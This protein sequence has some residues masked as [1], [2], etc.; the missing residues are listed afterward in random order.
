MRN[1]YI[2]NIGF[3]YYISIT[4]KLADAGYSIK[5]VSHGEDIT[6]Q[7]KS[8]K[9]FKSKFKPEVLTFDQYNYP[10]RFDKIFD[11]DYSIF[12]TSFFAE[13]AYYE[14]LFL[15]MSDR[16]CF[17]PISQIERIRL[18]H[19]YIAHAY[20]LFKRLDINSIIF[21]GTPHGPWNISIIALSKVMN[22][23]IIYTDWVGLSPKLTTIEKNIEIRKSITSE[24][25]NIDDF[26]NR[27]DSIEINN[28]INEKIHQ[29]LDWTSTKHINK[30]AKILKRII[31][32]A[33]IKSVRKYL[34]P[35]FILNHSN[36][37]GI[38]YVTKYIKHLFEMNDAINFYDKN[39]ISKIE[40]D[41]WVF[42][43]HFQPE[44]TTMPMGYVYSDQLLVL[45]IILSAAPANQRIFIK[46]HP[47]TY[48]Y[49][50][51]D[52][53]ERSKK[54]YKQLLRDPRVSF[55][56]RKIE[57]KELINKAKYIISICGSVSW[58]A[59][60]IGKP[61]I[62][63][64]W[65]WFSKCKSIYSVDS[66]ESLKDAF[67]QINKSNQQKVQND[68][69]EFIK[70]IKS[71]SIYGVAVRNAFTYIDIN[72]QEYNQ[73]I[74]NISNGIIKSLEKSKE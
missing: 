41:S 27:Q 32:L 3:D 52:R 15:L 38:N 60:R 53:H 39:S 1:L 21:F 19:R 22:I 47:F 56:N 33:T 30:N 12:S 69:D 74:N 20:K 10:E 66:T 73:F 61:S 57:S 50:A 2:T 26:E 48:E 72:G 62:V 34:G 55:L 13:I 64:G 71:E 11:P 5:I 28:V 9:N 6:Y 45:E 51:Q 29:R 67:A 37:L 4:R 16:L 36:R 44:A 65:A 35:E 18:F 17:T 58:E 46:E 24:K 70:I 40:K 23:D 31:A 49:P 8:L 42:F 63:F 43:L 59:L 7:S 68:F 25:L 54:F 14:K